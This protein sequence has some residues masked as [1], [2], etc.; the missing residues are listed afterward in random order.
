MSNII[1]GFPNRVDTATLSGGSWTGLAN[2]KDRNTYSL[3]RSANVTTDSTKFDVD[4]G[5][6]NYNIHA[7]S[8]HS[9][10]LTVNATWR[11]TVGTSAGASDVYDSGFI[12]VWQIAFDSDLNEFEQGAYWADVVNDQNVRS[13][14]SIVSTFAN[15]ARANQYIRVEINDTANT[16]GYVEIGR[17]G[18]WS[19]FKPAKNAVWGLQHGWDD[20]NSVVNYAISGEMNYNK[21]RAKRTVNMSFDFLTDSEANTAYELMRRAGRTGEVMYIPDPADMSYSQRYGFR[22]TFRQ[23][24][25]LEKTNLDVNT[26]EFQLTE[27]L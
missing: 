4:L 8:L 27:L 3:A 23:L 24:G 26:K 6:T 17:L 2:L 16:D 5:S 21:F 10:N 11:I 20:S 12:S 7:L 15:T 18:I 9:H 14:F 13:H 19:G 1:L 25:A 22:G